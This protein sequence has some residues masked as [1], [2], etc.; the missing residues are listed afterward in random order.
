M[1]AGIAIFD[2]VILD[3]AVFI[4]SLAPLGAVT[5]GIG[6]QISPVVTAGSGY[7]LAVVPI[8]LVIAGFL[9]GP[10]RDPR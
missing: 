10:P 4:N 5:S 1:A 2:Y 3:V 9:L 8:G 7:S 6:A